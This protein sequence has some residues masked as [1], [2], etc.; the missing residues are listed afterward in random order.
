MSAYWIGRAQT[1]DPAGYKP[2]GELVAKASQLYPQE[3]LARGGQTRQL[4]GETVFDRF[5]IIRFGSMDEAE[6]YYRSP[7]YQEAAAFRHAASVKCDLVITEG[8]K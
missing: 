6:R 4:E 2:Y 3:V 8:L 7:E 1:R 5:V